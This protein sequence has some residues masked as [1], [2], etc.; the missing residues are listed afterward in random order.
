MVAPA[1]RYASHVEAA[2]YFVVAEGLANVAK[3]SR[4]T[5]GRVHVRE[6]TS[7][8][9]VTVEDDG[10]GGVD[11]DGGTGLRGLEDRAEALGGHLVVE[12][13]PG[14]GTSLFVSIPMQG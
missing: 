10:I 12:S 7:Q 6:S 11:I 4:A 1:G 3:H 13:V 2:A 9:L 5:S 8:L 14:H